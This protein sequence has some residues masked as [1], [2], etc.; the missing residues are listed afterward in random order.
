MGEMMMDV[1]ETE[2]ARPEAVYHVMM[3]YLSDMIQAI[4]FTFS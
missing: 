1:K 3:P 4:I 2:R